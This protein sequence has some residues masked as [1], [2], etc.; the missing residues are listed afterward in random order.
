M[1][2]FITGIFGESAKRVAD[3]QY[4]NDDD[5]FTF[6]TEATKGLFFFLKM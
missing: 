1:C 5:F 4:F 2:A 3:K 6:V